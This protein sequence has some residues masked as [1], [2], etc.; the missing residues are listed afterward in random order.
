MAVDKCTVSTGVCTVYIPEFTV[1]GSLL[2]SIRYAVGSGE[3]LCVSYFADYLLK[4]DKIN[5]KCGASGVYST[6]ATALDSAIIIPPGNTHYC[7]I[8]INVLAA[9]FAHCNTFD[10]SQPVTVS[11]GDFTA[12]VARDNRPAFALQTVLEEWRFKLLSG[13]ETTHFSRNGGLGNAVD[14]VFLEDRAYFV[15]ND[16]TLSSILFQPSATPVSHYPCPV[17][18]LFFHSSSY[19]PLSATSG[20]IGVTFISTTLG[21]YLLPYGM[22]ATEPIRVFSD[23][24]VFNLATARL[25]LYLPANKNFPFLYSLL[26]FSLIFVV[27]PDMCPSNPSSLSTHYQP[28]FYDVI[29]S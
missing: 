13:E 18:Q 25:S 20:V 21:A 15:A 22:Q 14:F 26:A 1:A 8:V 5:V 11:S 3:S 17:D 10:H 2:S 29:S 16:N 19:F 23:D 28:L 24:L 9:N 6:S 27:L 12:F 4:T 7:I